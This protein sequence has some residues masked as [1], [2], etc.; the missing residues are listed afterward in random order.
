MYSYPASN[1]IRHKKVVGDLSFS[2]VKEIQNAK[3][4]QTPSNDPP[5]E[6]VPDIP[7]EHLQSEDAAEGLTSVHIGAL[8]GVGVLVAAYIYKTYSGRG[9]AQSK[10]LNNEV[11]DMPKVIVTAVVDSL[12]TIPQS[13]AEAKEETRRRL[14]TRSRP[15]ER[16]FSSR[17]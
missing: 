5:I 13:R 4:D 10:G 2:T 8:L 12:P 9:T 1:G 6:T 14:N 16:P 11:D 3:V 15:V 17:D 7:L